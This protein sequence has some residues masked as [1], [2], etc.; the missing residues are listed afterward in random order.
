M[1]SYSV[2]REKWQELSIFDQMG[3]IYSEVGRTFTA[4]K[5]RDVKRSEA[6]FERALDL[7]DATTEVLAIKK[8]SKLREVLRAREIFVNE[9]A[10]ASESSLDDY[11]MQFAIAARM[12]QFS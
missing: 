7:F 11:L 8:S 5:M 4:K 10:T 12:R 2:D 1:S 3:N 6:A 9:Y